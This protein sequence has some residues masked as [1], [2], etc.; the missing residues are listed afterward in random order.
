MIM[1]IIT[2]KLFIE[3]GYWNAIAGIINIASLFFYYLCVIGGNT[4]SIAEI[5]QPEINGQYWLILGNGKAW[6]VLLVLPMVALLPDTAYMLMQKIFFPTPTDAVML[7]QKNQPDYVFD[8]FDDVY[9]P[10][11][12]NDPARAAEM[13]MQKQGRRTSAQEGHPLTAYNDSIIE[14]TPM[15]N[16]KNQ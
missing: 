12:P 5:F 2:G 7:R 10:Q 8:G 1:Q 13:R 16:Q 11:L 6:I 3:T 15:Q 4:S 14:S 9:K